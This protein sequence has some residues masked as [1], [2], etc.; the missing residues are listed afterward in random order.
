[1]WIEN[2][3]GGAGTM[4]HERKGVD[5]NQT[6]WKIDGVAVTDMATGTERRNRRRRLRAFES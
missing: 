2:L 5:R 1:L 6:E 4:R 3:A